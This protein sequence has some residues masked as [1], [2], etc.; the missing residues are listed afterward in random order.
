[1]D[2]TSDGHVIASIVQPDKTL[3]QVHMGHKSEFL[4]DFHRNYSNMM[5]SA[6]LTDAERKHAMY[7]FNRAVG[8]LQ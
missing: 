8:H 2:K 1:M 5:A 4:P 7:H 6:N 3:K